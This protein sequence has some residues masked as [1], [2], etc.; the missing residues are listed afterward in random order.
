MG[1]EQHWARKSLGHDA[2]PTLRRGKGRGLGR[3]PQR[4]TSGEGVANRV[5]A[6]EPITHRMSPRMSRHGQPLVLLLWPVTGKNGPS[7][8]SQVESWDPGGGSANS[9]RS[10]LTMVLV[11]E[12]LFFPE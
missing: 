3:E 12:H 8:K 11:A 10:Q 4:C 6:L 1:A 7:L 2:D 5:G 9:W